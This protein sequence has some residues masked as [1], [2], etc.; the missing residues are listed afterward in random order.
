MEG[1]LFSIPRR[2]GDGDE[3]RGW[4][5]LPQKEYYFPSAH[6]KGYL[7]RHISQPSLVISGSK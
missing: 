2:D 7:Y 4:R 3:E 5:L 6:K 1:L